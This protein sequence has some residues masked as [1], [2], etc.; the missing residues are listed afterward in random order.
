MVQTRNG[1]VGARV[2]LTHK[3]GFN[4]LHILWQHV[5]GPVGEA[6]YGVRGPIGGAADVG[7]TNRCTTANENL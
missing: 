1:R 2:L 6:A 5:M 7:T 3:T 4:Q